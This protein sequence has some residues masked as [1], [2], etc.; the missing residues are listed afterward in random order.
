MSWIVRAS[1]S[2]LHLAVIDTQIGANTLL[3]TPLGTSRGDLLDRP[4]MAGSK[5]NSDVSPATSSSRLW[6]LCRL[7][8]YQYQFEEHKEQLIKDPQEKFL[9]NFKVDRNHKV[10]RQQ[11]TDLASL[12]PAATTPKVS[13]TNEI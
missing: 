10:V 8:I 2:L 4:P 6:R 5:D 13:E 1:P 11:V 3:A 7:K 9:A 12:R